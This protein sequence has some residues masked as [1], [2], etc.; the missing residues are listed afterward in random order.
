MMARK[1]KAEMTVNWKSGD[2]I[3]FYNGFQVHIK[4]DF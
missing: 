2:Q 1:F 3:S 4:V